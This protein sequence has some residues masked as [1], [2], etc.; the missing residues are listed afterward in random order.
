MTQDIPGRGALM[1]YWNAPIGPAPYPMERAEMMII[2]CAADADELA[3]ITPSFCEPGPGR[4]VKVFFA[5]NSQPPTSLRFYEIGVIQEVVYE[6]E[7]VQTIPYIWVSDDLAMLGG[8]EYF[9]MTKLL[10]DNNGLQ[11]HANQV[12][13]RLSRAGITMAEGSMVLH[14]EA[15]PEELP[16]KGLASVYERHIPHPNPEKPSLRQLIKLHVTDRAIDG[17]CWMGQGY[18]ET[19]HPLNSGLARLGLQ[20]T[21]RAWYGVYTWNLPNGEIVAEKEV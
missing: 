1:P 7:L 16:F 9:G 6:G 3:R 17:R 18:I 13:G 10:M 21:E 5:N 4:T 12:F 19:R 14:R 8:R 11:I 20:A 15:Q 2:E